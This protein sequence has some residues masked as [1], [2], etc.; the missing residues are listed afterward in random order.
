MS[1]L[2]DLTEKRRELI[3][4]INNY[5]E[6]NNVECITLDKGAIT[7]VYFEDEIDDDLLFDTVKK[8]GYI[9]GHLLNEGDECVVGFG[10]IDIQTIAYILDK[11]ENNEFTINDDEDE[12][13]DE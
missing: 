3:E 8:G 12:D 7:G 9:E 4:K 13:E 10:N 2:S 11:I 6:T 1:H 5:F